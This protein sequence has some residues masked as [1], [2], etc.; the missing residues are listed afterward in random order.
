MRSTTILAPGELSPPGAKRKVKVEVAH[1][2]E[3][4]PEGPPSGK[5]V[6]GE[7]LGEC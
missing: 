6:T 5:F 1:A 7:V 3:G 2:K 4:G